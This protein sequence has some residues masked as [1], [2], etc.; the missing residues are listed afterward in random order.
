M[1][2]YWIYFPNNISLER[3]NLIIQKKK[4]TNLVYTTY[5]IKDI[6][7]LLSNIGINKNIVRL[8]NYLNNHNKI[9][10]YLQKK[11]KRLYCN[12]KSKLI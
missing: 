7:N 1:K 2:I 10:N 6:K 5:K 12:N 9:K 3:S 8:P 4:I 11:K